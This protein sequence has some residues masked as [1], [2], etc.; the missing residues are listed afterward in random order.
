MHTPFPVG[1]RPSASTWSTDVARDPAAKQPPC[2]SA[3][4]AYPHPW[5][6]D[7]KKLK[8]SEE[9]WR[10]GSNPPLSTLLY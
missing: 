10:E 3:R 2:D 8:R 4:S 1:M 5:D 6:V 9:F 7:A